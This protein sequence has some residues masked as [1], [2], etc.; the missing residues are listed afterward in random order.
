L[1]PAVQRKYKKHKAIFKM[2][3]E[4][5]ILNATKAPR[6]LHNEVDNFFLF[7]E[8]VKQ[9]SL[10][11][12]KNTVSAKNLLNEF[13][14]QHFSDPLEGEVKIWLKMLHRRLSP[15]IKTRTNWTVEFK[16]AMS[17][18]IFSLILQSVKKA[19]S[20]YGVSHKEEKLPDRMCRK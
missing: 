6:P 7:E 18:G 4:N 15:R 17:S 19:G 14:R 10:Q 9:P 1:L 8:E 3:A 5:A 13:Q 16:R 11:L 20:A 2:A 12:L